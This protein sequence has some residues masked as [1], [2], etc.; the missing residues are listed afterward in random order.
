MAKRIVNRIAVWLGVL[1]EGARG[2]VAAKTLPT[3]SGTPSGLVIQL[4]REIRSPERIHVGDDVKLGPGC[5]LK[6]A[7]RYPGG[8]MRHPEG[9]QFEQTF[10]SS[11]TL[12]DRVT[13]TG[14]LHIA[15]YD[16][17]TIED[18]VMFATNVFISD[19]S[20]GFST[21]ETPYKFQPIESIQPVRVGRGSWIGQNVV[22]MPGVSVGELCVI[23][24]NS[25]VT[26]S[27]PAQSIAVGAPA[28]VV[29]R[30][31]AEQKA[32]EDAG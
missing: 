15:A 18:D 12:G 23:G 20:H 14:Q 32:W 9:Q 6:A 10:D 26:K 29:K 31:N 22:I 28:R 24:A 3:F 27:V 7:T 13:S 25:V 16:N 17:V 1:L 11:I 4:P 21:A 8:W 5:V 2:S 19:G 30:W